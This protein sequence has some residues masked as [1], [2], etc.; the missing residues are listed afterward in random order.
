M[1]DNLL[2]LYENLE[3]NIV[4]SKKAPNVNKK[5]SKNKYK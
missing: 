4:P 5:L 3:N 2:E 1:N